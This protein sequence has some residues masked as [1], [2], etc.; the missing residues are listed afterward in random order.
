MKHVHDKH[1]QTKTMF[2]F[3]NFIDFY[4]QPLANYS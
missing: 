3:V 2:F 1:V 4:K